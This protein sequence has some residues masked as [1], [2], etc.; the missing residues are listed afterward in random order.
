MLGDAVMNLQ[1]RRVHVTSTIQQHP[2]PIIDLCLDSLNLLRTSGSNMA[3][4]TAITS[5]NGLRLRC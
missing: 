1:L 3:R 4:D 5:S 2:F